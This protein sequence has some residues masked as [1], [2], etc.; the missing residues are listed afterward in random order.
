MYSLLFFAKKKWRVPNIYDETRTR[1]DECLENTKSK[2]QSNKSNKAL[3][4]G[5][6]WLKR[7]SVRSSTS[8]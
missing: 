1:V 4:D 3:I 7:I 6:M 5:F 2:A 8:V